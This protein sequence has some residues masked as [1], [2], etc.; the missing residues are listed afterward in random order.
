MY[1][2]KANKLLILLQREFTPLSCPYFYPTAALVLVSAQHGEEKG[3]WGS[4][5]G[6]Q[7]QGFLS[8][9]CPA[10]DGTNPEEAF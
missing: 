2:G 3:A 1:W 7:K 5:L 10:L 9:P 4:V 6:C 8:G